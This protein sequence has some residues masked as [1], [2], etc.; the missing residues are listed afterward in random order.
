MDKLD[1]IRQYKDLLVNDLYVNVRGEQSIDQQ[2][3]D[4]S[5]TLESVK[6]P[7]TPIRTGI[8]YR[9][10]TAPGEQ[11]ITSDPQVIIK[12]ARDLKGEKESVKKLQFTVNEEWINS[13]KR[14]VPN[15]FKES[16]KSKLSRG[17]SYIKV[18]HNEMWV[19]GKKQR[20]GMPVIFMSPDP[21]VI[22]GSPEED[23]CGWI[24]NVGV[25]NKVIVCYQRQPWEVILKYPSW[26]YEKVEGKTSVEWWEYWDKD[27]RYFECQGKPVLQDG[28]QPNR[29]GFVPFVRKYSG[30]GKRSPDGNLSEMIV[31]DIKMSRE[32]IKAYTTAMSD[33]GSIQHIF[34]H[35]PVTII[36]PTGEE[37]SKDQLREM[38]LGSYGVNILN[39][40]DPHEI[41]W[42]EVKPPTAEMYQHMAD[43]RGEI[44]QRHPFIM[45]GFPMGSSGRQQDI[46]QSGAMRR[47]DSIL[48]STQDEFAT[49]FEMGLK[50]CDKIP[51]L[52]PAGL[53]KNDLSLD[54]KCVVRL[55]ADDPIETDRLAT[56]GSRLY[57]SGEID[58]RTNLIKY[59]GY[60]TEETDEIIENIL[61]DRVTF[62]SPEVAEL[63]GL[64]VAEK[65][66]MT[67]ELQILRE[68]RAQAEKQAS[69]LGMPMSSTEQRRGQGEV[70]TPLGRNMI[71]EALRSKGQ[72]A[73]PERYF[74]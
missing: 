6:A 27:V 29:Y 63:M 47:Y 65:A 53:D 24:P 55:K 17:E 60:S 5:F 33:I 15:I 74:R 70:K 58:I 21:M 12:S 13:L 14:Q 19:T 4:D 11:I 16:V 43:L 39:L 25:P 52:K 72:R 22:Y 35:Q 71:D 56:L 30:F 45:A 41:K 23:D 44:Q 20:Y 54:F 18:V 46:M 57:Q 8:G 28:V 38:D 37:V 7:H 1:E 49:A 62:Q 42:G 26:V 51:T 32:L 31:S 9:V 2:Y 36:L 34:A 73:S 40:P 68:R 64:K 69:T 67:E 61:V 66:G 3:I 50:I 59:Q 10:V 48:E